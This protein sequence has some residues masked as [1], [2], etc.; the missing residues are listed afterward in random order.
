MSF[1]ELPECVFFGQAARYAGDLLTG[2]R[3]INVPFMMT[4]TIVFTDSMHLR[5]S[6]AA[7]RQ[8]A[9][10]QAYGPLVKFM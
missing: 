3:G 9:V 1:R 10:N 2:S 8:W 6:L 5:N 7:R 4:G